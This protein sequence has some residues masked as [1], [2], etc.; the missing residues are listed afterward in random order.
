VLIA[1]LTMDKEPWRTIECEGQ[2]ATWA[3]GTDI[4]WLYGRAGGAVQLLT[5]LADKAL[6]FSR[7][8]KLL[9]L[10]RHRIGSWAAR[11]PVAREGNR[12]MTRVPETY[13]NTNA[14]TVASLGY[15]LRAYE[16]DY[17][18]RTNTSTYVNRKLLA[19]FVEDLPGAG[20]YG[21]YV[22]ESNGVRFASGTGVLLSRDL[23]ER[24]VEDRQWEFNIIDDV[25]MGRCMSR[26]G[27]PVQH[28]ARIDVLSE[29]DLERLDG[30]ALRSTFLVR[31]KGNKDRSHDIQ[32][33]HR[34][35][36]IYR[37][38]GLA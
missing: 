8:E 16:F 23:V 14:K 18:L 31:C 37:E 34:V 27:V 1:V 22:G 9:A 28:F 38:F 30:S 3:T 4:L 24:I 26:L 15:I 29:Q 5:R 10:G 19:Q 32:A 17:L 12:I 13:I 20:Y 2:R 7:S 11:L 35:H 33:M 6:R 36:A 21:G 25:A